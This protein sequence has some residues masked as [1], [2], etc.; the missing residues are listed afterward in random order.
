MELPNTIRRVLEQVDLHQDQ[1]V[2]T[3][4]KAVA[5]PSVS[6]QKEYRPQTIQVVDYFKQVSTD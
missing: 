2:S 6:Q 1:F 5:I 3:L 4:A